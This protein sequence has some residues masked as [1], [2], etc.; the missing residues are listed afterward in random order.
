MV[1]TCEIDVPNTH[2]Y[3]TTHS[4]VP[5]THTYTTTHSPGLVQSLQ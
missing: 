3:T 5:N 1:E 2:T 4:D